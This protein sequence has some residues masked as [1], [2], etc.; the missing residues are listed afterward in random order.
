METT[1]LIAFWTHTKEQLTPVLTGHERPLAIL[2]P[3]TLTD[4]A[5][6]HCLSTKTNRAVWLQTWRYRQHAIWVLFDDTYTEIPFSETTVAIPDFTF[7]RRLA[8]TKAGNCMSLSWC[9]N[10]HLITAGGNEILFKVE[11]S[12][13]RPGMQNLFNFCDIT[14]DSSGLF[15]TCDH[16]A[17]IILCFT[18]DGR[19]MREIFTRF[20]PTAIAFSKDN[21]LMVAEWS[22]GETAGLRSQITFYAHD[23]PVRVIRND[24][25]RRIHRMLV[26]PRTGEIYVMDSSVDRISVFT[27][28]GKFDRFVGTGMQK[29]TGM[30]LTGD[31]QLIVCEHDCQCLSIFTSEGDTVARWQLQHNPLDLAILPHGKI[32]VLQDLHHI[33]FFSF[34]WD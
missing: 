23:K 17:K 15:W 12:V 4:V 22:F 14:M 1:R 3:Q 33:E 7:Q 16:T 32:A 10:V 31:G 9:G 26:C 18:E 19:L 34:C 25:P 21:E 11:R 24:V 27:P 6:L 20:R 29:P 2:P 13:R 8:V 30:A 28:D 5:F